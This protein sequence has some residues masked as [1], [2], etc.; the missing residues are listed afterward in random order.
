METPNT[1]TIHH[2]A[3]T[4]LRRFSKVGEVPSFARRI[5]IDVMKLE[6][7]SRKTTPPTRYSSSGSI[8]IVMGVDGGWRVG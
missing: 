5:S 6:S 8:G 2:H 7:A 1:P 3:F 4:R